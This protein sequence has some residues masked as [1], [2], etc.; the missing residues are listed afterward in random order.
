MAV[1]GDGRFGSSRGITGKR[2]GQEKELLT[3]GKSLHLLS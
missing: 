3:P 1:I 2:D